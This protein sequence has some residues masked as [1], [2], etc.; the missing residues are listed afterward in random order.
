MSDALNAIRGLY[1]RNDRNY[2]YLGVR[3]FGP[4]GEYNSRILIM[5][6][7]RRMSE[8]IFDQSFLGE[9]FILDMN[10]INRIEYIYLA[11]VPLFTVLTLYLA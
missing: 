1:V 7:G 5:I 3:G 2:T 9:D 4:V 10:I 11:Q 8:A 6:N